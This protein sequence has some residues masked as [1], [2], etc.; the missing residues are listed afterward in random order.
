M[1]EVVSGKAAGA[2]TLGERWAEERGVPVRRFPAQWGDVEGKPER[3]IGYNTRGAYWKRA[4]FER[5]EQ[6]KRYAAAAPDHPV[7]GPESGQLIAVRSGDTP[8]TR[9][10]VKAASERGLAV[11]V[12]DIKTRAFCYKMPGQE[13]AGWFPGS[14]HVGA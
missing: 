5:N 11:F 2:D 3:E 12:Y 10:M 7:S 14:V 1:T 9:H 13:P 6:M 8:G 4:G